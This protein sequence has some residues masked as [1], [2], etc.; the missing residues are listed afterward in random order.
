MFY[1]DSNAYRI[2]KHD[3]AKNNTYY[4]LDPVSQKVA[5]SKNFFPVNS[6]VFL[7]DTL[8]KVQMLVMNDRP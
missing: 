4:E 8:K 7:E 5:V 3:I 6:G 1:S 2:V